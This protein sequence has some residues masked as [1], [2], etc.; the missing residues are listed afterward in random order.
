MT[1][2]FIVVIFGVYPW[3]IRPFN[4]AHEISAT[5]GDARDTVT[6]PRFHRGIDIPVVSG[7]DVFS[8]SS[9]D[10][11][12]VAADYVY[13]PDAQEWYIHIIPLINTGDTV[14]GIRDTVD[15]SPTQIGDVADY[16]TP[17][18]A[19]DHLHFQVGSRDNDGPYYNPLSYDG[20][21]YGYYDNL[22]PVIYSVDLWVS[23]SDTANPQRI[24]FD[25]FFFRELYNKNV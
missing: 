9:T 1:A 14:L 12:F 18:P 22:N 20:G 3:P 15:T 19:G 21:P 10:S 7:T 16:G 13:I 4:V 8:I 11:A 24:L 23:G 25:F 5:L 17:G 2:L 6:N